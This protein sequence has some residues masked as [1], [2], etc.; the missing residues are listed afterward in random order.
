[1]TG[2]TRDFPSGAITPEC[3]HMRIGI[4]SR[5]L[6]PGGHLEWA[7]GLG[8]GL[9]AA[10]HHVVLTFVRESS[11][12]AMLKTEL[13]GLLVENTLRGV[14]ARLST[15][16]GWALS[17]ALLGGGYGREGSPDPLSW[18]AA[19]FFGRWSRRFDLVVFA[20]DF[21]AFGGFLLNRLNGTQYVVFVH[22]APGRSPSA[23]ADRVI[24]WFRRKVRARASLVCAIDDAIV[25]RLRDAGERNAITIPSGCEPAERDATK[26]AGFVLADSRWTPARD[27][28]FLVRLAQKTPDTP[29][30]MLGSFWT[31][32]TESHFREARRRSGLER[33]ITMVT[34]FTPEEATEYYRTAMVYVR[35]AAFGTG[36]WELGFPTGLRVAMSQ[37]C[38]V[39]FDENLGC[40]AEV[41]RELKDGMVAHTP[42]AFAEK[43]HELQTTPDLVERRSQ[44]AWDYARNHTWAAS[45]ARLIAQ[46]PESG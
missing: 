32:E 6:I 19:P 27:P 12:S 21:T 15:A 37:G 38:P 13:S 36:G 8:R 22:E 26:R 35:W 4:V 31:P 7:A 16:F 39:L 18:A 41:G 9:A 30:V 17:L 28:A 40:A 2:V 3:V 11:Y 20:E 1:V 24:E 25:A 45:A 23:I 10:G 33:Q 14:A 34:G 46:L 43:I 42:E 5:V 29:Y 44:Q